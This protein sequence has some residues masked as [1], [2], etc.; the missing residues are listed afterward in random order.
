MDKLL[1]LSSVTQA[2]KA[3]DLLRKN[4]IISIVKRIPADKES[5][6][7]GYGIYIKGNAEKAVEILQRNGILM[8]DLPS[9]DD[10]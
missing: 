7:C 3:R 2:M 6:T 8:R 1:R 4:K 10:I 5:P 9:N